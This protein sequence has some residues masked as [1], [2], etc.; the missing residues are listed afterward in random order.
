MDHQA[1]HRSTTTA[2]VVDAPESALNWWKQHQLAFDRAKE[3]VAPPPLC[4]LGCSKN[5]HPSPPF[6]QLTY[7]STVYSRYDRFRAC[8]AHDRMSDIPDEQT[9]RVRM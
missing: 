3:I 1:R 5:L 7:G 6:A 4:P 8:E 2:A 9:D